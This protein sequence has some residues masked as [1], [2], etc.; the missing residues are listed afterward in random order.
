MLN[1]LVTSELRTLSPELAESCTLGDFF[2][3]MGAQSQAEY[4]LGLIALFHDDE[5]VL[6]RDEQ[7][8]IES[9][10]RLAA[11][12]LQNAQF[13]QEAITDGLTGLT[14]NRYLMREGANLLRA[15][16]NQPLSVFMLDLDGFKQVNDKYGHEA[17]DE[18]LVAVSRSVKS[19]VRPQDMFSR[20]GGD[21]FVLIIPDLSREGAEA[22]A[23]EVQEAVRRASVRVEGG[24]EAR[25]GVSIGL[26]CAPED[27]TTL[28][29]LLRVA[30]A[31]MYRQK[32]R[33]GEWPDKEIPIP[34]ELDL[35]FIS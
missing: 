27:G 13:R 19:L 21:E 24:R 1:E 9:L 35:P 22:R 16:P 5:A 33:R 4:P 12:A 15:R 8:L 31:R 17:G 26:A 25:V 7:R 32:R 18:I 10:C 23:L 30:D 11:P 28:T 2:P 34:S 29:E 3:L 14:N 20:K 6:N